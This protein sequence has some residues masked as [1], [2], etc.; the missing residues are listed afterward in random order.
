MG[1]WRSLGSGPDHLTT[2]L[3]GRSVA[4]GR[5]ADPELMHQRG[6][7]MLPATSPLFLGC[8]VVSNSPRT[9]AIGDIHG[10]VHALDCLLEAI[11]PGREDRLIVLGDF[12]D[13]GHETCLVIDRLLEV[14]RQ[15]QLICLLGNHEEMFLAARTSAEARQ[16]WETCGGTAMLNSYFFGAKL[17][18]VPADHVEFIET[19]RDYFETQQHVFVHANF[20][21][22]LPWPEQ[23]A[24]T[25]R[26]DLLDPENTRPHVSGKRV[27]VGHTEQLSG[28]VLDLGHVC[29]IDTACWRYGWLTALDVDTGQV[30]QASRFGQL[31]G[32][33]EAPVGRLARDES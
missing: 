3:G 2:P 20:D 16:Y 21:P 17:E 18:V 30:W 19:C 1:P 15:C 11:S 7:D 24:H 6:R 12:I 22:N 23:P 9:I 26:W 33:G 25:L 13:Q 5:Q 10:C 31:R 4:D 28:E 27:I 14:G 8:P 29:C 32:A